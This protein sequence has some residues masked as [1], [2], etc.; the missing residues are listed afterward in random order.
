[1]FRSQSAISLQIRKL[2]QIVGERLFSRTARRVTLTPAGERL[3]GYAERM[4]ALHDE[5]L[6]AFRQGEARGH[7]RLGTPEDIATAHLPKALA[8][9]PAPI[10]AF[11]LK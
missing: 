10:R 2:E 8:G 1:L 9:S 4:L 11:S 7:V 3:M 6:S 5:A